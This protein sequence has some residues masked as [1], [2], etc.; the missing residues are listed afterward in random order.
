MVFIKNLLKFYILKL[1]TSWQKTN[2]SDGSLSKNNQATVNYKYL[3][4]EKKT[5]K[6]KTIEFSFVNRFI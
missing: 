5:K 3:L 6:K 2:G 1:M 4:Y